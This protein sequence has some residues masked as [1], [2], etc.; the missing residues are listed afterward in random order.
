MSRIGRV[1]SRIRSFLIA[2]VIL[3]ASVG[4]AALL[5]SLAPEPAR[6]EPPPQIPF[7]QTDRV[8]ADSGAIPVFGAGTVRP[9]AEVDV[10]PQVGGRV[11]WVDPGF[12]SGGRVKAGQTLFRL[13]EA[14][15]LH[16]VQE[17][18]ASLAARRVALLQ[19]EEQAAIARA[20]FEL[21]SGRQ[22]DTPPP[23]AANPLALREPQLKAARAALG[24]D[25]ALLAAAELALARTRVTAPFDGFVREESVGVGQI[26]APGQPVG[27]LFAAAAVEV[28]V[29]LTNAEA[30][31]IPGLWDL[32]PGDGDRRVGVRV[33]ARYGGGS[34]AWE[35]Y[36]DRAETSVDERTRTI[37][38]IVRVP[39]PFTGS[40]SPLLVGAF[41]EVEIEGL[42][43]DRYYKVP[44]AAMRPGNEVWLAKEGLVSIVAVHVLQR[45]DDEVFVTGGLESGQAVI[46]GGIQFATEGMRVLTDADPAP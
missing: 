18:R 43:L 35:G 20:Q 31:L 14:D 21:Y 19:E 40:D 29:P 15:Y 24:R 36:V 16:R 5:V 1:V 11:V 7:A 45:G 17:A 23:A 27:R 39:D 6:T 22:G 4:L 10:A 37:D 34:R 12:Q 33:V 2:A 46:T 30:D 26:V 8:T 38:V 3:A 41:V 32:R 44:R 13:E 42:R 25:E 28:V 9:S